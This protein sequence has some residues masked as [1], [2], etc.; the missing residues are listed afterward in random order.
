MRRLK[1]LLFYLIEDTAFWPAKLFNFAMIFLIILSM[2]VWLLDSNKEISASW[3]WLF[4]K[5]EYGCMLAFMVE[6]I[7]RL[8]AYEGAMWKF[9]FKPMS[10]VDALAIL[11]F[12]ISGSSDTAALRVLRIFRVFRIFKLARYSESLNRLGTVFR[13][14]AGTLGIFLFVVLIILFIAAALMHA[15]EPVRFAQMTDALWW[16]VVTLT[17]VGYGDFV[18]ESLIGRAIAAII[19]FLGIGIIALPTGILG[20][21]LSKILADEKK[22]VRMKCGRCG[23][24]KH[25]VEARYCWRCGERLPESNP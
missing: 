14:N 1:K 21:S 22:M 25:I 15:I 3:G 20:A 17:T 12:F 16:A 10:L 6:Y 18:P 24:E 5:I 8:L 2:T 23:E 9:P 13:E 7:L 19:M 11:P 4:Q